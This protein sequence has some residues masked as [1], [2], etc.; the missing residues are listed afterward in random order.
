MN[1]RHILILLL[2]G[3]LLLGIYRMTVEDSG[4]MPHRS[5]VFSEDVIP[6]EGGSRRKEREWRMLRDPRTGKIPAGI[7]DIEMEWVK[8]MPFRG[9]DGTTQT[10]GLMVAN[11]YSPAGP[12]Q[13][14][15]RT[16]GIAFDMRYN[17]N[18]NR[19]ILAG[20]INGG[21]FRSSDGEQPGPSYI[22]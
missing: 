21:I 14:G 2:S 9:D 22:L 20:G 5:R 4:Q 17:G 10:N 12:T 13:N 3:S 7:R 19:V 16:R 1:S 8:T 6:E 15:G 11:T 18:T